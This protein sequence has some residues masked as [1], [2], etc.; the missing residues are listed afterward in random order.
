MFLLHRVSFR[1][2]LLA[3]PQRA[4]RMS[5]AARALYDA[6]FDIRHTVAALRADGAGAAALR[7]AS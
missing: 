7:A 6:R 3:E 4:A 5:A 1:Q 2:L